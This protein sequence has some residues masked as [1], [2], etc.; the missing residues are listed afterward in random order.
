VWVALAALV[1][2]FRVGAAA[3]AVALGSLWLAWVV[4]VPSFVSVA[5]AARHPVPPRAELIAASRRA[6]PIPRAEII[7]L[8]ERYYA[9]HPGQRPPGLEVA[10]YN[11]PLYWTAT[12]REAERRMAPVVARYDRARAAQQRLVDWL[13]VLSPAVVAQ[14]A[15]NDLAGTGVARHHRFL[16]AVDEFHRAHRG[17]YEPRTFAQVRIT[18]ADYDRMPRFAFAEEPASAPVRRAAAGVVTLVASALLLGAAAFW[19]ARRGGDAT[20]G[21]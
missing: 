7:P 20:V 8:I 2:T 14:E 12:Q 10:K 5:A 18:S 13:R 17:F 21:M 16:A 6:S 15:F 11:F 19:R 3:C 9:E 4:L 1:N